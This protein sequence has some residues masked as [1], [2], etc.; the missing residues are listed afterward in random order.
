MTALVRRK[1]LPLR[2][3]CFDQ[4]DLLRAPPPFDFLLAC[5]RRRDFAVLLYMNESRHFVLSCEAFRIREAAMPGQT[6]F[7][8][9]GNA[10]VED[11]CAAGEDVDVVELHWA[12]GTSG[13]LCRSVYLPLV[14]PYPSVTVVFAM[15]SPVRRLPITTRMASARFRTGIRSG[16]LRMMERG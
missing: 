10:G 14:G 13:W 5:D 3:C 8:V 15:R 7:E 4:P 9:A 1:V 12:E 2:V 16:R 11:S 6:S